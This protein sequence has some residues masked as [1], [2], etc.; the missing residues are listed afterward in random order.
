MIDI[1]LLI[2]FRGA[3]RFEFQIGRLYVTICRPGF[4][5]WGCRP[6][7]KIGLEPQRGNV[8]KTLKKGA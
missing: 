1:K 4:W 5:V 8:T 2:A 6:W 3:T 7:I